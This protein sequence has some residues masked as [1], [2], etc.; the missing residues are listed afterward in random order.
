MPHSPAFAMT[1]A[2]APPGGGRRES[3]RRS[4]GFSSR[5][6]SI[7][8]WRLVPM[9]KLSPL[10]L[11]IHLLIYSIFLITPCN[12]V[13]H[14]SGHDNFNV[15]FVGAGNIM[16]GASRRNENAARYLPNAHP[17]VGRGSLESL[18]PFGAVRAALFELQSPPANLLISV[19]SVRVSKSSH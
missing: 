16:F 17:R 6:P 18:L 11:L 8:P 15:V 3:D 14:I 10:H 7:D 1:P 13:S 9:D 19:N 5:R 2:N 4:S 12:R